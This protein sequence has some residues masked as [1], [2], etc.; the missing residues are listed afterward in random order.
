MLLLLVMKGLAADD[1]A[2][3]GPAVNAD[4]TLLMLLMLLLMLM[5]MLLVFLLLLRYGLHIT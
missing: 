5:L 4:N 2:S 3:I 1:T